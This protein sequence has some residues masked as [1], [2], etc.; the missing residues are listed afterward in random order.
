MMAT[1][2]LRS[3]TVVKRRTSRTL[4]G[5]SILSARHNSRANKLYKSCVYTTS[6][7]LTRPIARPCSRVKTNSCQNHLRVSARKKSR[8]V[9][10]KGTR[11]IAT[12]AMLPTGN[13]GKL[14]DEPRAR[15]R[16]PWVGNA[17]TPPMSGLPTLRFAGVRQ[18]GPHD[19]GT[20]SLRWL[21]PHTPRVRRGLVA[22][23]NR[24]VCLSVGVPT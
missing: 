1:R 21:Q 17:V 20:C 2:L 18:R 22:K 15:L 10:H 3:L 6:D 11:R 5:A 16:R 19:Y 23:T 7:V 9:S 8:K 12:L 4:R 24:T 14:L 13:K